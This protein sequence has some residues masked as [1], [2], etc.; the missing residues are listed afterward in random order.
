MDHQAVDSP[1]SDCR[2]S[3]RTPDNEDLIGAPQDTLRC[4]NEN[5]GSLE[6]QIEAAIVSVSPPVV[7]SLH[8][9]EPEDDEEGD[10]T[11]QDWAPQDPLDCGNENEH[12]PS[13]RLPRYKTMVK[14]ALKTLA[15]KNGFVSQGAIGSGSSEL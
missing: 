12:T 14:K 3:S 5:C 13:S 4:G 15:I 9:S 8:Q 1:T 10:R 7:P 11:A 2:D 6:F